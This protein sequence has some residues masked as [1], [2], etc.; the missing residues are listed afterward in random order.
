MN[1]RIGHGSLIPILTGYSK[2]N[3]GF[4]MCDGTLTN[5]GENHYRNYRGGHFGETACSFPRYK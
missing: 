2:T 3:N 1:P 5:H 4:G